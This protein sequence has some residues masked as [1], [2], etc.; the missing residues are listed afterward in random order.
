MPEHCSRKCLAACF[1]IIFI[2]CSLPA[3]SS[4]D[5]VVSAATA[6]SQESQPTQNTMTNAPVELNRAYVMGYFT[7]FKDI[8]TSPALWDTSDWITAALVTGMAAGL[9]DNDAK[10]QKWSQDHKTTTTNDIGDNV[11]E[12]GHGKYT[13]VL[14]GGLY[15]Y[16]RL[17]GD[18]KAK[19]TALLSVESFVVTGVLVTVL[20]RTGGRH[21]P[22]TGDP[23]NTWD[24]PRLT[25]RNQSF[26][27]GH[28]SLSFAVASVIASEYDNAFVPPLAY[29][30][31]AITGLNRVTRNAHWASDV[32]VA[33]AIGYFTG[34]GIVALHRREKATGLSLVPM[35]DGRDAGM[36]LV[37]RF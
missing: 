1:P 24:G 29:G 23:Y 25:A 14:V 37:Y 22:Y 17:A 31:A 6:T 33:S 9:Y 27:S 35:I 36:M 12:L 30:I 10:I 4:A 26:P 2:C 15:L 13:T 32:F 11:T 18:G 5:D 16:G 8:V 28:A 19:E 21:R 34:K 3:F 20:K 7:D